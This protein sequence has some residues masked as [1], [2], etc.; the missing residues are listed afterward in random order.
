MLY[1][2]DTN[3][4]VNITSYPELILLVHLGKIGERRCSWQSAGDTTSA[5][6]ARF[7]MKFQTALVERFCVFRLQRCLLGHQISE[8]RSRKAG[9]DWTCSWRLEL[10]VGSRQSGVGRHK[11]HYA[12]WAAA[13]RNEQTAEATVPPPP[14][15]RLINSAWNLRLF[16]FSFCLFLPAAPVSYIV[17]IW[18]VIVADQTI[19]GWIARMLA[20]LLHVLDAPVSLDVAVE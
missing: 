11:N 13:T 2:N 9:G 16:S 6:R 5:Y 10:G 12:T 19:D 18:Q 7:S 14:P 1:F 20:A 17:H 8:S 4:R 15:P 3:F